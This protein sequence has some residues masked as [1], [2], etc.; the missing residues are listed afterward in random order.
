MLNK[1]SFI[2][3]VGRDPEIKNEVAN[4]SIAIKEKF[5]NKSGENTEKTTW[6]NLVAF[7]NTTKIIE[8]YIS[9][10]SKIFVECNFSQNKYTDKNG[11]EKVSY[12]FIIN[13]L[14]MLDSAKKED[15]QKPW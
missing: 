14:I 15:I 11:Q 1:C 7:G 6:V 13:N 12:N 2:G 5:K 4:F 8:K 9:K 3:H 10:G